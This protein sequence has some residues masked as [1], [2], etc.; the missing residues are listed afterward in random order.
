VRPQATVIVGPYTPFIFT[1]GPF[2]LYFSQFFIIFYKFWGPLESSGPQALLLLLLCKS[3][4]AGDTCDRLT[5]HSQTDSE[6][7]VP[8]CSHGHEILYDSQVIA[9][10]RYFLLNIL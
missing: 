5:V 6:S 2:I 3:T 1:N 8:P 4:T 10:V 7:E 9:M